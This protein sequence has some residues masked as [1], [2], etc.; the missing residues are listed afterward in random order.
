[1]QTSPGDKTGKMVLKALALTA[2]GQL[3]DACLESLT[4]VHADCD[5]GQTCNIFEG[6]VKHIWRKLAAL[7]LTEA[8]ASVVGGRTDPSYDE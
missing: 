2:P 7:K 5:E 6:P 1:M 3:A 4:C 8:W